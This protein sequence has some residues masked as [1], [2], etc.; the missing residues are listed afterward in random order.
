MRCWSGTQGRTRLPSFRDSIVAIP[1][2]LE[3]LDANTERVRLRDSQPVT[4]SGT[5]FLHIA[6][7]TTL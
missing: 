3:T 1:E 4:E 7:G 2:V 5:R 6:I